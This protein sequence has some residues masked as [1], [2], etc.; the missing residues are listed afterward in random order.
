MK[1]ERDHLQSEVTSL[2]RQIHLKE[3]E[4]FQLKRSL[5]SS[6]GQGQQGQ[7]VVGQEAGKLTQIITG[8]QV[9]SPLDMDPPDC[10]LKEQ[11]TSL[12]SHRMEV[13][14]TMAH[15]TNIV[16]KLELKL[17]EAE[18]AIHHH[19][20]SA[21]RSQ[22]GSTS[23]GGTTIPRSPVRTKRNI[24][25]EYN[26]K[27]Y[28]PTPKPSSGK[29]RLR[30]NDGYG[31]PPGSEE[32]SSGGRGRYD[33]PQHDD[34]E[35][36][37]SRFGDLTFEEREISDEDEEIVPPSRERGMRG[38][39]YGISNSHKSMK[40]SSGNSKMDQRWVMP[41]AAGSHSSSLQVVSILKEVLINLMNKDTKQETFSFK[42]KVKIHTS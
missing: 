10:G 16:Q 19:L 30:W 9:L 36:E 34:D 18:D 32:G 20:G 3:E 14:K 5:T 15:Q 39:G 23:S 35:D 12:Q 1:V 37:T 13:E 25:R 33:H 6:S 24:E 27:R 8:Q 22:R 2:Q 4:I 31:D 26:S 11:I 29:S 38:R 7:G 42:T 28:L 41:S 21:S 40:R 17:K